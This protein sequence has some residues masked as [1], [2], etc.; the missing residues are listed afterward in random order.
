MIC[1][2]NS[3][4]HLRDIDIETHKETSLP[5]LGRLVCYAWESSGIAVKG[6]PATL[7]VC[8]DLRDWALYLLSLYPVP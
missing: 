3:G 8:E 6:G 1:F 5:R 2:W 4:S 7:V